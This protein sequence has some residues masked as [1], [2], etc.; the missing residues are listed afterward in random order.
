V[1]QFD[2]QAPEFVATKSSPEAKQA[3]GAIYKRSVKVPHFRIIYIMSNYSRFRKVARACF[4]QGGDRSAKVPV[5]LTKVRYRGHQQT[6][7][8]AMMNNRAKSG[9]KRRETAENSA[10]EISHY[11]D[12]LKYHHSAM[13]SRRTIQLT[14]FT[15]CVGLFLVVTKGLSDARAAILA[16]SWANYAVGGFFFLL[17][18]IY[19]HML[20]RMEAASKFDRKQYHHL[21]DC[22]RARIPEYSLKP[23]AA[24]PRK[25]ETSFMLFLRAWASVPPFMAAVVIA[26]SCWCFIFLLPLVPIPVDPS[27]TAHPSVGS[28]P[29]V[30]TKKAPTVQPLVGLPPIVT[31]KNAP[32]ADKR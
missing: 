16:T 30:T 20:L 25:E 26:I 27:S 31:P 3:E 5:H 8:H 12:M 21:E 15:A 10:A 13:E 17:L 4:H 19:L 22:V 29:I 9:W 7:H 14:I 2:T 24:T 32:Y 11:I 28:P 23:V 6:R 1:V 18:A